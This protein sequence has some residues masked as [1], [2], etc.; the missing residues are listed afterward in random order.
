MSCD[1]C[2]SREVERELDKKKAAKLPQESSSEN[3]RRL[4]HI[5]I[6]VVCHGVCGAWC[7]VYMCVHGVCVWCGVVWC[8]VMYM[9]YGV[10]GVHVCGVVWY[11]V[12]DVWCMWCACV[13][14]GAVYMMCMCLVWCTWWCACVWCGVHGV[15][16]VHVSVHYEARELA[17]SPLIM[18]RQIGGA[19]I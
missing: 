5:K 11:G 4:R 8:G 15:H 2:T 14:C 18:H 7:M 13:W 16:D 9:M 12:H 10:C 1:I 19:Y 3:K 6:M 17:Y